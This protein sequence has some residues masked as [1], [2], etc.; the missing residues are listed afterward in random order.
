[1]PYLALT[2]NRREAPVH[3]KALNV[4]GI[5]AIAVAYVQCW[6]SGVLHA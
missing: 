1:M 4:D 2:V 6:H 3:G 5:L